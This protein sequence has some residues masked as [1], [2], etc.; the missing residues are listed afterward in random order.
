MA[1]Q[2]GP[3]PSG[4]EMRHTTTGRPYFINHESKETSWDD[5]RLQ[6]PLPGGWEMRVHADGRVF[7]VDHGKTLDCSSLYLGAGR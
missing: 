4:W 3:L 6:Q 2:L 5:P 1:A 7:Y